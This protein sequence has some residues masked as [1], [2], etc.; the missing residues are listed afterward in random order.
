MRKL[1][2]FLAVLALGHGASAAIVASQVSC[3]QL[4]TAIASGET[5][6]IGK[7]GIVYTMISECGTSHI[8]KTAN[9]LCPVWVKPAPNAY[10]EPSTGDNNPNGGA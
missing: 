5:Q 10:C 2:V 7:K 6:V 1:S 3:Y 4:R 8:F 9:G